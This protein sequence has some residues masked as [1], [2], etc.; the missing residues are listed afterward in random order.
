[1]TQTLPEMEEKTL[2]EVFT[3]EQSPNVIIVHFGTG[4]Q[5]EKLCME[6]LVEDCQISRANCKICIYPG[7]FHGHISF[8]SAEESQRFV[9]FFEFDVQHQGLTL[10]TNEVRLRRSYDKTRIMMVG[11]THLKQTDMVYN[12]KFPFS[13]SLNFEELQTTQ[14]P[15]QSWFISSATLQRD[16][17]GRNESKAVAKSLDS[18]GEWG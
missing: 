7:Y 5:E 14:D 4:S 2:A 11:F 6:E 9:S 17:L 15:A 1:M 8:A 16:F 12:K 10:K 13:S 18:I 3:T